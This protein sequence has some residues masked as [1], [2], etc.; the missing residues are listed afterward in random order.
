MN[1]YSPDELAPVFYARPPIAI[2]RVEG[3]VLIERVASPTLCKVMAAGDEIVAID[4]MEVRNYA[5]Q[6][7]APFVSSSTEQ[8]RNVRM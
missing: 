1:N 7:I 5:E 6:R 3:K 8:D 4:G 2:M